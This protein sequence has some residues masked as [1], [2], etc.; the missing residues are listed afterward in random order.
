MNGK[1]PASK[2][3]ASKESLIDE[4]DSL[5]SIL[6]ND[7]SGKQVNIPLLE[8]VESDLEELLN[9]ESLDIPILTDPCQGQENSDQDSPLPEETNPIQGSVVAADNVERLLNQLVEEQLPRLEQL[10]RE[11]L[12]AEIEAGHVSIEDSSDKHPID[13]T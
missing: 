9:M 4:L 11:R 6:K 5:C 1:P 12:L 3:P 2:L 7:D 10:L 8:D 13:E